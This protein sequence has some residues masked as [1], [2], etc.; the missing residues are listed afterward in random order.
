MTISSLCRMNEFEV[1]GQWFDVLAL[2]LGIV[3]LC[4]GVFWLNVISC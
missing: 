3:L 1:E 2:K 4:R